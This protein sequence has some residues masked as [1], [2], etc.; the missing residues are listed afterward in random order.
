MNFKFYMLKITNMAMVRKS[1][2][3]SDKFNIAE[4]SNMK[5]WTEWIT[6]LHVIVLC[7]HAVASS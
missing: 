1:D 5:L 4:I 2:I 7:V 3:V 6:T